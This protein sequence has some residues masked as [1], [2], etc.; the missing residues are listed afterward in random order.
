MVT[1]KVAVVPPANTVTEAGTDAAAL[2]LES[3]TVD[4]VDGAGPVNVTVPVEEAPPV[5]AVG[6]KVTERGLGALTVSWAVAVPLSVAVIVGVAAETLAVVVT[7]KFAVV[8]PASTF[9]EAGTLA[10]ALSLESPTE[11]PPEGAGPV[12][13]TVP[14]E[15]VPPI[16]LVGFRTTEKITGGLMVS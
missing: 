9:T 4:P 15:D 6:L 5:T 10:A 1:V 8:A 3:P 12:N 2:L 11:L 14:V 7:V 13:V 16:T